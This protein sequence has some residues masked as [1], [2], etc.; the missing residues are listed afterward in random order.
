[1]K[2][3]AV[4]NIHTEAGSIEPGAEGTRIPQER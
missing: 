1:M 2:P 3:S 4:K